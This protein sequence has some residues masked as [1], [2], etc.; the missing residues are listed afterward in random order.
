MTKDV[1]CPVCNRLLAKMDEDGTLHIKTGRN[2]TEI[3]AHATSGKILLICPSVYFRN[4]EPGKQCGNRLYA[5]FEEGKCS[6]AA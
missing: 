6:I 2:G 4:R 1:R 3:I 5:V